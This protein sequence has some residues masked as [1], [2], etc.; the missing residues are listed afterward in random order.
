VAITSNILVSEIVPSDRVGLCH[1]LANN[2]V[3]TWVK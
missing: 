3:I 2:G 1:Q